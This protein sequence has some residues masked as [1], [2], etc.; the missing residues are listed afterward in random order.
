VTAGH[1]TT[2]VG[3]LRRFEIPHMLAGSFASSYHGYPRTT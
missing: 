2:I 3:E 1:L